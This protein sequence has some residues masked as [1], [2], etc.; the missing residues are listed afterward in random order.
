MLN[1]ADLEI[2]G[3]M[4]RRDEDVRRRPYDDATGELV[5][6][7]Q[8]NI[9]IGIGHNL[10]HSDLPDEVIDLLF[11]LDVEEAHRLCLDLFPK[12]DT[13]DPARKYALIN[14]AFNL[15][16]RLK[17][18]KVMMQSIDEG[19]WIGAARAAMN[20]WWFIQVKSRGQ[21]VVMMLQTNKV[22]K[23]YLL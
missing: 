17:G 11:K 9:T 14:M 23:E 22:P 4:L 2:I 7:P 15:G 21:R 18:F 3:K 20:S 1:N 13:F 6:A 8:G 10:N 19:D 5:Y 16:P 12:F